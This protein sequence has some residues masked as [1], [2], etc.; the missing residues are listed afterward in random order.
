MIA[1][2]EANDV[3]LTV[4]HNRR[5]DADWVTVKTLIDD[6]CAGEVFMVE[7]SVGGCRPLKGWRCDEKHGGGMLRDWG[8]HVLDQICLIA[9]SPA[10][11][12][13]ASF[14]HRMW[15][16]VMDVP[17]HTQLAI[18]FESGMRAQ[19]TFSNNMWA[20]KPRWLVLGDG[21]GLLK[22]SGGGGAVTW[23]HGVAGQ[24][25]VTEVP[26]L[27]PDRGEMYQ[28]VSDHLNKGAELI[29]KPQ[30]TRRY[31]AIYEAAYK[32]AESGEAVQPL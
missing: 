21:G 20:P 11:S 7:C 1:A 32:S 18:E 31:V 19:A 15:T 23:Y 17:T 4:Y 3:M 27:E 25:A 29:V 2:S 22:Q 10:A 28:N 12:V 13:Y 9:S 5:W 16:D 6:G 24:S 14:E 30:E 8:A 26:C